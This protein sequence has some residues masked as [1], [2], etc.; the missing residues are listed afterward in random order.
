M[1][2]YID[3]R[4][5]YFSDDGDPLINGKVFIFE[6][7]SATHKDLFFD[8][9]LSIAAPN[10]VIL[11]A[12]GRMPNTFFSGTATAKLTDADEAQ[13]WN[14]DPIETTSAGQGGFP[15]WNSVTIWNIPDVVIASDD[16]FYISITNAN[17]GSDPTSSPLNWSQIKFIGVYNANETYVIDDIVQASDGLL[18]KSNIN[19]NAGNNPVSDAV[20]WSPAVAA[21]TIVYDDQAYWMGV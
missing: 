15:D 13:I 18:Y 20:S 6:S 10:P 21:P 3:P 19:S 8:V 16:N 12:S 4:P 14:I 5:Q 9:N 17:Q 2:R 1:G 11:S 7:G